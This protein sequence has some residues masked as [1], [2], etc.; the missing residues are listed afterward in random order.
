MNSSHI[1]TIDY[2]CKLNI[3]IKEF[4]LPKLPLAVETGFKHKCVGHNCYSDYD[5]TTLSF[6]N[7]AFFTLDFVAKFMVQNKESFE[8]LILKNLQ[9]ESRGI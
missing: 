1:S 8:K 7:M 2:E 4:I 9:I 5:V 3:Q 6:D